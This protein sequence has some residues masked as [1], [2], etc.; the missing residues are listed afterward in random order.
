MTPLLSP[1]RKRGRLTILY[2][3]LTICQMGPVK[4]THLMYR[5]NL[6]HGQLHKFV[7][8]LLD[9]GFCTEVQRANATEYRITAKGRRFVSEFRRIQTLF[10]A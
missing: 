8:V 7:T 5:A 6:S 1:F 9:K 3:M 4:R 10:D 2:E